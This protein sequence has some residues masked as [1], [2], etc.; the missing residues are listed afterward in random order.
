MHMRAWERTTRPARLR[1]YTTVMPSVCPAVIYFGGLR[2]GR[3]RE[4]VGPE[5]LS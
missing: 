3:T 2:V 1:V 5:S 4:S